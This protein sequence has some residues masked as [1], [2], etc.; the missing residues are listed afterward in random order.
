MYTIR[1]TGLPCICFGFG[2]LAHANA[3]PSA[4]K[5]RYSQRIDIDVA[6]GDLSGVQG[7]RWESACHIKH[8]DDLV[9]Q[10]RF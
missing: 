7:R 9:G 6:K 5:L 1:L 8:S 3:E 10:I 2:G 4:T